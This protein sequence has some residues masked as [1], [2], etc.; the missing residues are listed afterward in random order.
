VACRGLSRALAVLMSD[1]MQPGYCEAVF[2]VA[3]YHR[4]AGA[5]LSE[6][7]FLDAMTWR[8]AVGEVRA[9]CHLPM[10]VTPWGYSCFRG[11]D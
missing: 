6:L 2:D 4:A 1:I 11:G 9:H 10:K 5:A 7:P 3:G 8:F